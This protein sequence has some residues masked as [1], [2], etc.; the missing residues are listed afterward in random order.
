VLKLN[1][2]DGGR[3][4]FILCEMMEYAE[5]ITAERVRRVIDGYGDDNKFVEGTGGEFDFYQLGPALFKDDKNLNEDVGVE[6]LRS[7]VSYTET[8]QEQS[9]FE[10]INPVSPYALGS[11]N[12]ALWVFYYE[13]DRVTTLDLDF[14]ATLNIADLSSRPEQFIIYADKCALDRDFLYKHGITFKRIPRD[15]T[16][17]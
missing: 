14:L 5:N 11:S 8:I 2:Q 6:A 7:Y 16:R 9:R 13:R 3:R 17:F 12:S 1:Q 4:Q 10:E 15:I